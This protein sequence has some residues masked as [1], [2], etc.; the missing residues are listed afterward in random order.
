MLSR[1][2]QYQYPSYK[3]NE[4][5][6]A[7]SFSDS[8]AMGTLTS[9]SSF[10]VCFNHLTVIFKSLNKNPI[11]I[12]FFYNLNKCFTNFTSPKHFCYVNF[13]YFSALVLSHLF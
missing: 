6:D 10:F 7:D 12:H 1:Q 5:A 9:T 4:S 11:H 3:L 2:L 8:V 13:F